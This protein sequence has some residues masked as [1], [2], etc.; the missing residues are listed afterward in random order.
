MNKRT[1]LLIGAAIAAI[2]TASC[3]PTPTILAGADVS[4]TPSQPEPA[5]LPNRPYAQGKSLGPA[6][7]PVVIEEYADFQCPWSAKFAMDALRQVEDT[8]M[9]SGAGNVRFTYRH[10]AVLGPESQTAAE[11][12]EC[13][14]EQGQFWAYADTLFTNQR[15][16]G[17]FSPDS[18]KEYAEE[19]GLDTAAF[20]TCL[21]SRRYQQVVEQ[22]TQQ[23]RERN[24]RYTPTLL[25]NDQTL[26]GAISFDQLNQMIERVAGD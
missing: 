20:N 25:I 3:G 24:V 4:A 13:A 9:R 17:A 12:S 8:Y 6:D 14:N 16:Q 10:M 5:S 7:A 26:V 1:L 18:L 22:E 23:G 19:L 2:A 21:D 11:A 15:N